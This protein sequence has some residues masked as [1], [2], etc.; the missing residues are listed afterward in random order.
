[1][2]LW[3]KLFIAQRVNILRILSTLP[4]NIRLPRSFAGRRRHL[5][6]GDLLDADDYAQLT[7]EHFHQQWQT[8]VPHQQWSGVRQCLYGQFTQRST[9]YAHAF[10]V[11]D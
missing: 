4:K 2:K 8:A 7:N 11:I 10:T 9:G 1:M 5:D 3:S 6:I